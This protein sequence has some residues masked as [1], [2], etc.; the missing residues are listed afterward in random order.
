MSVI[1]IFTY[2]TFITFVK[3]YISYNILELVRFKRKVSFSKHVTIRLFMRS[4]RG[5]SR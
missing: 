1:G 3:E 5:N 2:I 4:E